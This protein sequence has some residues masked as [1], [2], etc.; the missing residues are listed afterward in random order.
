MTDP[1]AFTL[2]LPTLGGKQL[3]ADEFVHR[4]YRIQR[5]TILGFHRLLDPR[6][7]RLDRG[8]YEACA[9]AFDALAEAQDLAR[10]SDEVVVLLHGIFRAKE[11]WTPMAR[12][13]EAAGFEAEPV[14][15]PSTQTGIEVH[16]DQVER[17][18][19]RLRGAR[20][21]SFVT[22]SMGGLVAREL[23]SR[24]A[25]WR[26]RLTVNRLVMIATPNRGAE[27][28]DRLLPLWTFRR[29]A[30][31]AASQLTTDYVPHL[32]VPTVPFGVI[33][34]VRGDG[35][36]FNPLLAGEDDVTV[37]L[38]STHLD[39]AEDTLVVRAVHTFILQ[40]PAVIE[41]TVRYLRTGRF[42]ALPTE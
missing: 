34:G 37:S 36:G 11:G 35:R 12:A 27:M 15:Y 7:L 19:D 3:W 6:N 4:R 9:R 20:R 40:A 24:D 32:P 18:L 33:A 22:H 17:L 29:L 38:A 41:A 31:P 28:A 26:Q 42:A 16:A 14:N 13:L 1:R 5:N 8:T 39:G 2:P 25:P 21:V 23:L 10:H 30:G